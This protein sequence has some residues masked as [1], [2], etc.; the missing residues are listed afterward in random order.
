MEEHCG[1]SEQEVQRR[2]DRQLEDEPFD[3]L[4]YR[5]ER[6]LFSECW[7][8]ED[9]S[10]SSTQP[11]PELVAPTPDNRADGAGRCFNLSMVATG[12]KR[13]SG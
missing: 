6:A 12:L 1:A 8:Y 3:V 2:A 9:T 4:R 7:L 11:G 5:I 10:R 13:T